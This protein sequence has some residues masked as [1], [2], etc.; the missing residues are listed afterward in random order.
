MVN[1]HQPSAFKINGGVFVL[2]KSM[3][4]AS[5]SL[6]SSASTPNHCPTHTLNY[7]RT[8]SEILAEAS[9]GKHTGW[10][11]CF[12]LCFSNGLWL[13]EG[14]DLEYLIFPESS[15]EPDRK[16]WFNQSY[17]WQHPVGV[18][19]H[20]VGRQTPSHVL[21]GCVR[22]SSDSRR[23]R[24]IQGLP[25]SESTGL[26]HLVEVT[27]CGPSAS[28]AIYP[29]P[30]LSAPS[31]SLSNAFLLFLL[32]FFFFSFPRSPHSMPY[33]K[34]GGCSHRHCVPLQW[35]SRATL[36]LVLPHKSKHMIQE[37]QGGT[38]LFEGRFHKRG[39]FNLEIKG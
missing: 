3:Q 29:S 11:N 15:T 7:F 19:C 39:L 36:E 34:H 6:S 32:H 4:S 35:S 25:G 31:L 22:D 1:E 37:F 5:S 14:R 24:V 28:S 30:P 13:L 20:E 38:N 10:L 9:L 16:W 2:I 8:S 23:E 26:G 17:T 21:S 18:S 12:K 33:H 27:W